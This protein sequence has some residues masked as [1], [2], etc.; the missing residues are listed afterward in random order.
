MLK[1][2]NYPRLK[3]FILTRGIIFSLEELFLLLKRQIDEFGLEINSLQPILSWVKEKSE[4]IRIEEHFIPAAFR[5]YYCLIDP[6]LSR[7]LDIQDCRQLICI[8]D[9]KLGNALGLLGDL[10]YELAFDRSLS[11]ILQMAEDCDLEVINSIF[12]STLITAK[13]VIK[14]FLIINIR[15]LATKISFMPELA[16]ILYFSY[17]LDLEFLN[18]IVR[19]KD[20]LPNSRRDKENREWWK[21]EGEIWIKKLREVLIS[22]RNIGHRRTLNQSHINL[23]RQYFKANILLM[24]CLRSDCCVSSGV[25]QYIE[26]NLLYPVSDIKPYVP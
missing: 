6:T 7:K 2:L 21:S 17:L 12:S 3:L 24:N 22:Y 14:D 9:P 26:D 10:P 18:L 8:L 16:G 15:S 13:S 25:S 11:R 4:S 19:I 5:V 23:M 20:E 1:Q